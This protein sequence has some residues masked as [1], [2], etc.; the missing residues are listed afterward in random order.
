MCKRV[1]VDIKS[2]SNNALWGFFIILRYSKT[3]VVVCA[4]ILFGVLLAGSGSFGGLRCR[5]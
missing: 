2:G 1:G 5:D 4:G 3:G